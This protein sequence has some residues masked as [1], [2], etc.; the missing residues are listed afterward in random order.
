MLEQ[1]ACT[2]ITRTIKKEGE[3]TVTYTGTFNRK[4][5]KALCH[6]LAPERERMESTVPYSTVEP[7]LERR[8][9]KRCAIC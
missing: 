4:K 7:E 5:G 2:R 9:K 3:S 1:R 8:R 6:M